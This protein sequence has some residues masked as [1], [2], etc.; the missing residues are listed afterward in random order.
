MAYGEP[1]LVSSSKLDF[2]D[3]PNSEIRKLL[4]L[5]LTEEAL[6]NGLPTV[7]QLLEM[8]FFKNTNVDDISTSSVS[9][10][11]VT[12]NNSKLFSSS[13]TKELITKAKEFIEKR[14]NEE[15]KALHKLKRHNQA[16]AK[17]LSEGEIRKRRKEKKKAVQNLN[18]SLEYPTLLLENNFNSF[19]N[20]K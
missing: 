18:N 8:P 13:K 6:K 7:N 17:V 19:F 14:M 2:S 15:Q 20:G 4:E 11:T 12:S 5:L 1:L 9:A 10:A 3:C 16:E